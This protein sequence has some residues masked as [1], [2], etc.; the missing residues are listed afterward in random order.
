MDYEKKYKKALERAK[1]F[2][3]PEYKSIMASI[4]PELRES[5]DE[6]IRIE[7][8][9]YLY[10]VHDDDDDEERADWIA[11]L[12]KQGK[13]E[14]LCD[15]CKKAQPSHS[16]QDITAL[17]RCAV[18]HE[19]KPADKVE[20]KFHEGDW[21]V[22]DGW[23]TQIK[24]V[25]EDGYSNIHQGFIPK[26]REKEMR[27][28]TIQD[29]KDGDVL[30]TYECCEPKIV[31]II[32]GTPKIHYALSYHCYYNIM[33]SHFASDS[34]KGCLAP[35]DEDVKP[36]TKEQRDLLFKKMHEA[37]YE[38]DAKKKELK[39]IED[40]EY[41]GEDYGIDGLWHAM[42]ILEKTLGKVSGYQTDD[43]LLSHQCA[44][45]AIKKLYK[46]KLAWS[47]ED[48]ERIKNI[49][50]VLDVQVCWDGATGKKGNP[51][52]K[53][54]N[55]LKSLRP[56]NNATDE[57]LAQARKDAYNDALDKIEYHSG[58]PT[59]DDGWS[60][61]IWYLKKRIVH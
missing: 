41:N 55:W 5:E 43:G 3:L 51:Y 2:E 11:W 9:N 42:N 20:P 38:W 33:Y 1:S 48:E 27:L 32:K 14:T 52:Q 23:T 47:E 8:L 17:G 12:E 29:A 7:L 15:K 30:C 44:I 46:Q 18:E 60:A 49:I 6:K 4:F 13:Q 25:Y 21:V 50:S 57:E 28:W 24:E 37:G 36:A 16:C 40:E 19:Q 22:Y 59:F 61:A 53:E 10:D 31:F 34:E 56:Q 39:K 35:N 26:K 45:T 54:I 58:E